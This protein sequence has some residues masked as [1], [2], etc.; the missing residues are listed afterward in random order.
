MK[1]LICVRE[2]R[3]LGMFN[4][5]DFFIRYGIILFF[6]WGKLRDILYSFLKRKGDRVIYCIIIRRIIIL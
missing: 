2:R 4:F 6:F 3:F 1:R 5:K